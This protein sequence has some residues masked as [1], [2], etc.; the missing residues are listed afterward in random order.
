MKKRSFFSRLT[1]S[2][3]LKDDTEMDTLMG[4]QVFDTQTKGKPSKNDDESE[5]DFGED[6]NEEEGQL[7]MDL[8]E[9][10]REVIVQT[11]IAGVQ[12][13]DLSITITRDSITIKGKREETRSVDEDQY[14]VRE[15]WW[16]SFSRTISL[17]CEVEPD[18]AEATERHGLLVIKIPKI[19]KGK[20]SNPKVKSL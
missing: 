20:K 1:G 11:M 19:D 5:F 13:D 15:L 9:T 6:E 12:P 7:T 17:P 16:G 14:F 3:R 10:P 18:D 4:D 8:Y 2:I